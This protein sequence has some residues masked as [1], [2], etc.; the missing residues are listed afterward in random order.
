VATLKP[1]SGYPRGRGHCG[2]PD[3]SELAAESEMFQRISL[4]LRNFGAGDRPV[5][6][7]SATI[8]TQF[9]ALNDRAFWL[10]TP[11]ILNE[12]VPRATP[13]PRRSL[14]VVPL[15]RG[16]CYYGEAP[17]G[18]R[19]GYGRAS[20]HMASLL[21]RSAFIPHPCFF[22][23]GSAPVNSQGLFSLAP[24]LPT[25]CQRLFLYQRSFRDHQMS[26]GVALGCIIHAFQAVFCPVVRSPVVPWSAV[27]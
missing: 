15:S 11:P 4:A 18:L 27:P 8:R 7:V 5:S 2:R 25:T 12:T 3:A 1:P 16:N 9:G 6:R 19:W 26:Q 20:G 21:Q 14:A 22:W 10:L 23:A 13:G 24:N 17:V